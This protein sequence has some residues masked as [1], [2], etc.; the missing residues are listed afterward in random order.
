MSI[1]NTSED[2]LN[3]EVLTDEATASLEKVST[4]E[5][6][7]AEAKALADKKADEARRANY[8]VELENKYSKNL[9]TLK[10]EFDTKISEVNDVLKKVA[11]ENQSLKEI[12]QTKSNHTPNISTQP[13]N[14]SAPNPN[15]LNE[16]KVELIRRQMGL[17]K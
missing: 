9:D 15:A 17:K 7:L 1:E 5:K 16:S 13:V 8:K 3:N 2:T 11:E 10:Q 6:E 4:L 14:D 12:L